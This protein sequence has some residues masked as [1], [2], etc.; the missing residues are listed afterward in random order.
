LPQEDRYEEY[1]GFKFY[2]HYGLLP[3]QE[4]SKTGEIAVQNTLAGPSL[5]YAKQQELRL[6]VI[7]SFIGRLMGMGG[8]IIRKIRQA[9][10]SSIFIS[11]NRQFH[12]DAVV[13]QGRV[14]H[15]SALDHDALCSTAVCVI[16]TLFTCIEGSNE[17][18]NFYFVIPTAS[19]RLLT[20]GEEQFLAHLT[21][22]HKTDFR[23]REPHRLAPSER[24]LTA[25]GPISV[26]P[27]MIRDRARNIGPSKVLWTCLSTWW[28]NVASA[29]QRRSVQT[30]ALCR[31][32][33]AISMASTLSQGQ[34]GRVRLL[35]LQGRG[36][37]GHTT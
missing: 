28:P 31:A 3:R 10:R 4:I 36:G 32:R 16:Q 15:C 17:R 29:K 35:A 9:H 8:S 20:M 24:L 5:R 34:G 13:E 22:A 7:L 11:G 26:L 27:A 14:I 30:I 19:A 1:A 23:L 12:P 2:F 25:T 33:Q 21:S 6:V 37:A 18:F